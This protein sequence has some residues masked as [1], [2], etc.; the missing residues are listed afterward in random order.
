MCSN[1]FSEENNIIENLNTNSL[2]K[3]IESNDPAIIKIEDGKIFIKNENIHPTKYGLFLEASNKYY[4]IQ[5]LRSSS[6]GCYLN[7]SQ[8]DPLFITFIKCT[9]CGRLF[10]PSPY[11]GSRC[12]SCN[13]INQ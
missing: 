7:E 8:I 11:T 6:S 13:H 2:N 1:I 5:E 4:L 3:L 12:P 9:N 10:S